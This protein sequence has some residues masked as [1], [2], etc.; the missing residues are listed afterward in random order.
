MF[1]GKENGGSPIG[2]TDL[3]VDVF[4]VGSDGSFGYEESLGRLP[5]VEAFSYETE[6]LN[7]PISEPGR[8]FLLAGAMSVGAI[9]PT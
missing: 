1:H 7:L 4:Q 3:A 2:Y 6:H 5:P 8:P 9:Y